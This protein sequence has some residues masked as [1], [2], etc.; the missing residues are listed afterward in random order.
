MLF[1]LKFFIITAGA[2]LSTITVHSVVLVFAAFPPLN[3]SSAERSVTVISNLYE[4][5]ANAS[6]VR[7]SD[8][9]PSAVFLGRPV[10]LHVRFVPFVPSTASPGVEE[11]P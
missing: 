4:P 6:P 3:P 11:L 2:F 9:C 10:K 5:D 7:L 1:S 8:V